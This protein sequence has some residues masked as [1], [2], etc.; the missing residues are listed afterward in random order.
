MRADAPPFT[1]SGADKPPS[2]KGLVEPADPPRKPQGLD[3]P[4]VKQEPQSAAKRTADGAVKS[5]ARDAKP[6]AKPSADSALVK[7]ELSVDTWL[8]KEGPNEQPSASRATKRPREESVTDAV[9]AADKA[10][11]KAEDSQVALDSEGQNEPKRRKVR[12]QLTRFKQHIVCQYL[13]A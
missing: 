12:M 8:K 2:K 13:H 5:A 1:P 4:S 11:R 6:A 3:H 7:K 10:P 9:Q